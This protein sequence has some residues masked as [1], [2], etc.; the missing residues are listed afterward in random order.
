[1]L[2]FTP[3]F[4]IFVGPSHKALPSAAPSS[5]QLSVQDWILFADS[6]RAVGLIERRQLEKIA[7]SVANTARGDERKFWECVYNAL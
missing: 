4:Q 2:M 3:F 1:M 5:Y 7:F 6:I